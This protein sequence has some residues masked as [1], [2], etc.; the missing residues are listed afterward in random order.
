MLPQAKGLLDMSKRNAVTALLRSQASRAVEC[1]LNSQMQGAMG[2]RKIQAG[3]LT[4]LP[5]MA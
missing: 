3:G 1:R 5:F 2:V 4:S